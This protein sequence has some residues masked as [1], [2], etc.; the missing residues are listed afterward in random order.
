MD[1][2][3]KDVEAKMYGVK[4]N[5]DVLNKGVGAKINDVEAKMDDMEAKTDGVEV[6]MDALKK[7]MEYLK[8]DLT[9][10]LQEMLTNGKKGSKG[11]T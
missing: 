10:F 3:K 4:A 11:N 9:N 1:G 2:L 6:K 5:M 8:T 7:C